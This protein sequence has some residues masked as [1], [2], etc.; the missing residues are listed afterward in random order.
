MG[1]VLQSQNL[2]Q[3]RSLATGFRKSQVIKPYQVHVDSKNTTNITSCSVCTL[4]PGISQPQV[5]T[6]TCGER[7]TQKAGSCA[8]AMQ[9]MQLSLI[10]AYYSPHISG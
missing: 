7:G 4:P 1:E 6:G 8:T 9:S 5:T 2:T 10:L 3:K